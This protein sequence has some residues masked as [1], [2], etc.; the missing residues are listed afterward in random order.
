MPDFVPEFAERWKERVFA[1][2]M[3]TECLSIIQWIGW[4]VDGIL[5]D[6]ANMP[7]RNESP[8]YLYSQVLKA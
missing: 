8:K 3:D 4:A 2:V 1:V 7:L 5:Y 6:N